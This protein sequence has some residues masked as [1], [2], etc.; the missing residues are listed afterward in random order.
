M[1]LDGLVTVFYICLDH[2]T[3]HQRLMKRQFYALDLSQAID[4]CHTCISPRKFPAKF[5]KQSFKFP[6]DIVGSNFTADIIKWNNQA[7]STAIIIAVYTTAS[8]IA[9]EIYNTLQLYIELYRLD[10]PLYA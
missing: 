4:S 1:L 9:D 10:S 6:P 3:K 5:I 2:P 7:H 8:I